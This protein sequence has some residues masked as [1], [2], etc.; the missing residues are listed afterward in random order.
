MTQT[1]NLAPQGLTTEELAAIARVKAPSIRVRLCQTGS[2]W[3]LV[4]HK[5]PNG[6]LIWPA[7]SG[8]RLLSAKEGAA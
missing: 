2:F 6:R 8:E 1:A 7:D 4:P 3:G 5:M